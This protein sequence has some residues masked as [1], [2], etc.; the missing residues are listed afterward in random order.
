MLFTALEK[1]VVSDKRNMRSWP[2]QLFRIGVGVKGLRELAF[3]TA[4]PGRSTHKKTQYTGCP[5]LSRLKFFQVPYL[6]TERIACRIL[7]KVVIFKKFPPKK[8]L[9]KREMIWQTYWWTQPCVCDGWQAIG[10]TI[11]YY[12]HRLVLFKLLAPFAPGGH[13]I[14]TFLGVGQSKRPA[15]SKSKGPT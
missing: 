3:F 10:R 12:T 15:I 6:G 8:Y 5:V 7:W 11:T 9:I 14:G 13:L 4:L 2:R 1:Y